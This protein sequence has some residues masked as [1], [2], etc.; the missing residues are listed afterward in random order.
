METRCRTTTYHTAGIASS[1][2][3]GSR[4]RRILDFL[5]G[6]RTIGLWRL[7]APWS[8]DDRTPL[9]AAPGPHL[10]GGGH[11]R[12]PGGPLPVPPASFPAAGHRPAA[13]RPELSD[14]L[15]ADRRA[16]LPGPALGAAAAGRRRRPG[17]LRPLL[18][19]LERGAADRRPREPGV[20]RGAVA[21]A[22]APG[23]APA[24]RPAPGSGA[25]RPALPGSSDRPAGR[26]GCGSGFR[27]GA[28]RSRKRG[29]GRSHHAR[30]GSP[31]RR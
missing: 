17:G 27:R 22:G 18:G 23:D 12:P 16:R 6:C 30:A 8:R 10:L 25:G 28:C 15:A 19:R 5:R 31:L 29:A 21:L 1:R 13:D 24:A 9:G 7:G 14:G 26:S 11:P 3:E 4:Y 2:T 20:R